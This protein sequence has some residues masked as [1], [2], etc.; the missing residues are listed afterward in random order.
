MVHF[1]L[2]L[3]FYPPSFDD[4]HLSF[5]LFHFLTHNVPPSSPQLLPSSSGFTGGALQIHQN[6]ARR[7][8]N[9]CVIVEAALLNES[10]SPTVRRAGPSCLHQQMQIPGT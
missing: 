1:L 6:R 4:F 9:L 10:M 7:R 2:L 8:S 3:L 5:L